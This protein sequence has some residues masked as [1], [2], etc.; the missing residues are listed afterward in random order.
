MT[1]SQ[2]EIQFLSQNQL[3]LHYHF[4]PPVIEF[5]L[6]KGLLIQFLSC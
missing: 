4:H 2:S 6:E 5:Q 1:L 3:Y